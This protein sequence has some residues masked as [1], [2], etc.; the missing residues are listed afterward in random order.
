MHSDRLNNTNNL[1]PKFEGF[2]I[3]MVMPGQKQRVQEIVTKVF[4]LDWQVKSV[5]D[6]RTE[7]QVTLNK[8][9]Y[10]VKDAWDK[11]YNLR[12]QPGVVDAQP[13]F[14]V[15]LADNS[16]SEPIGDTQGQ[17]EEQSNDVEWGLKQVRVFEAW[18]RF[19]PDPKR[20][21][22]HDIIIGLPD[23]GYSEHPEIIRNLLLAKG[24]DFLKKDKDPKDELERS[25]GEVINNPGHGTSTASI[26]ISPRGRQGDYLSGKAVTG[27]APGAKVVPLRVSYSVV[28]LSVQNLAEAIEYAA[29]NNIHVL[30]ISLGTGFFNQRLRSA[31]IY[32]QKRG[33]IIVAASGTF[34][35]YVVWPAAYDEV[36]AVT[37]SNVLRQI[38]SGASR[39]PQVDVT[40][41]AEKVWYA[42]VEKIDNELRY[43]ILQ[44]S[45]TSFSAPLVA[46]VAA[47]WLSYHGREQLIKRYGAEKIPFIFNQ[48]LRDSCEKFPTW[49]P[50]KFGAG[51]VNAEKVL[52]APLPDNLSRTNFAPAIALQQHPAIDNGRLE[53]FAHLFENQLSDS[54]PKANF[55]A[56]AKDN[57]KLQA[58]LAELLQT[59]ETQL[60]QRLKEVG[61]ELAFHITTNPK[62]YQQLA[63]TLS[64]E[65]SDPNQLK[66]K[67]LTESSNNLDSV[68]EI[69]LQ[70]VS[71][72]LK[73]K[74][75]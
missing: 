58:S 32:A 57:T 15:P 60:P 1:S 39:G 33:V 18:S 36:I 19:F 64:T 38:W 74:L 23:T 22:G 62:L 24:Y 46:G 44:G 63:K 73:T 13:L 37:G 61:Q 67:S 47:L 41:P 51:I 75:R 72:V 8:K 65:K 9:V 43:N 42:K 3:E 35:P 7:F 68:R 26:A 14:A 48:I 71:E 30:S 16:Q 17:I 10:S 31:I 6:N 69:L 34:V 25:F 5:G 40:A 70:N 4:G 66:T 45:G 11:S 2:F 21:P 12:S 55:I 50:N 27:V 56:P 28:L 59:T 54:Q 53:T 29:D 52:A 20:P 49:K